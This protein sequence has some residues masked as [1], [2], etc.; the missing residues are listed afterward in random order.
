MVDV[1]AIVGHGL[2]GIFFIIFAFT[3]KE[4]FRQI[5]ILPIL[6]GF[7]V[8]AVGGYIFYQDPLYQIHHLGLYGAFFVYVYDTDLLCVS[9]MAETLLFLDHSMEQQGVMRSAHLLLTFFIL[10]SCISEFTSH[11]WSKLFLALQGALMMA[12]PIVIQ[13]IEPPRVITFLVMYVLW[14][15]RVFYPYLDVVPTAKVEIEDYSE[16]DP[17]GDSIEFEP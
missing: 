5:A 4:R 7:I 17:S 9:L 15:F 11:R 14:T 6:V 13:N 1:G 12:L 16:Y 8:E 10:L 2:P 3:S